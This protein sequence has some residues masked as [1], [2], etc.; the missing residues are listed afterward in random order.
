MKKSSSETPSKKSKNFLSIEE[1]FE[2]GELENL[3]LTKNWTQKEIADYKGISKNTVGKLVAKQGLKKTMAA[4]MEARKAT[5]LRIYG[6]ENVMQLEENKEKMK[7]TNLRVYGTP[8]SIQNPQVKEKRRQTNIEKY[9]YNTPMESAQIREKAI[10]AS[11][12]IYGTKH[13][14]QNPEIGKK[15][16]SRYFDKE[17]M[18][19]LFDKTKFLQ[20]LQT[21]TPLTYAEVAKRLGCSEFTARRYVDK[22]E[23]RDWFNLEGFLSVPEYEIHEFLKEKGVDSFRTR[24]ILKRKEEGKK[25]VSYEIDLYCPQYEIG[26]EYNGVYWHS[27]EKRN[28]LAH[29]EKCVMAEEKGIFLFQVFEFEWK[30]DK[31]GIYQQIAALFLPDKK[32]ANECFE[33]KDFLYPK[34][35]E[36]W[37]QGEKVYSFYINYACKEALEIYDF[38]VYSNLREEDHLSFLTTLAKKYNKTKIILKANRGKVRKEFFEK[39]SFIFSHYD[40]PNFFYCNHKAEAVSW[41]EFVDLEPGEEY[42]SIDFISEGWVIC[43]EGPAV[44]EKIL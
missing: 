9:G 1:I 17:I 35:K 3:Y 7:Q 13:P 34:K 33:F 32:I 2:E 29:A 18:E 37:A 44:F 36:V 6:V 11:F 24:K 19:I 31:E 25:A 16:S 22:Y 4:R 40:Y 42:P 30:V 12:R 20:T 43:D 28:P 14:N 27:Q 15:L 26:I 38:Q 39:S 41:R 23:C 10:E 21:I 5:N 8:S